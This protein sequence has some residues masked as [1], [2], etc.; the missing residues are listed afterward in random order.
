MA[1]RLPAAGDGA[2]G[3][4]ARS[5]AGG[6]PAAPAP[7]PCGPG[8]PRRALRTGSPARRRWRRLAERTHRQAGTG[9]HRGERMNE[10]HQL[11]LGPQKGL[12][13]AAVSFVRVL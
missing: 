10:V 1:S 2:A 6:V 5:P 8:P 7:A 4:A 12:K 9:R 11:W 3:A 13:K